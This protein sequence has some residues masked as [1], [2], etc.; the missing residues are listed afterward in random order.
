MV[1]DLIVWVLSWDCFDGFFEMS[2]LAER[3]CGED[4]G[5]RFWE[6]RGFS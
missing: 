6:E 3:K 4:L 5:L 1:N 2:G